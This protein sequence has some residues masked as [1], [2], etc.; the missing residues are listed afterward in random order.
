MSRRLLSNLMYTPGYQAKTKENPSV[1]LLQKLHV[2]EK[3]SITDLQRND[4]LK[5]AHIK[6]Q[7]YVTC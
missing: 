7:C 4:M 1:S 6:V 5:Y 2:G 3:N